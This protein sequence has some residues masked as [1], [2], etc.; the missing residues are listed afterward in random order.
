[1]FIVHLRLFFSTDIQYTHTH[2]YVVRRV[3][4]RIENIVIF[5]FRH[6]RNTGFSVGVVT[7]D[8]RNV[9]VISYFIV[10]VVLLTLYSII[11]HTKLY[12]NAHANDPL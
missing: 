7:E 11:V 10:V 8:D 1:M 12:C 6:P 4:K 2:T 9:N 3:D 5:K